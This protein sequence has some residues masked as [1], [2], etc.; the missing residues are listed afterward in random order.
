M[1]SFRR[2]S[3]HKP[4]GYLRLE[5]R[6]GHC[7]FA[8]VFKAVNAVES[9]RRIPS[10][11]SSTTALQPQTIGRC[12]TCQYADH[13]DVGRCCRYNSC[14]LGGSL[15]PYSTSNDRVRHVMGLEHSHSKHILYSVRP[16]ASQRRTAAGVISTL[17]TQPVSH[18]SNI[19]G[20]PYSASTYLEMFSLIA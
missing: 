19:S 4:S 2:V 3:E 6:L 14:A 15:S 10:L 1:R 11:L 20:A 5:R 9:V 7:T 18:L 13:Q 17:A 12:S 8:H 16:Q